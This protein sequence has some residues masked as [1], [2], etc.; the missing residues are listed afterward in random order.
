MAVFSV[1]YGNTM[2]NEGGY[3]NVS[4]DK[5]GETYKG[6][7][8][9][10]NPSWAGWA[11]I[12]QVK[13]TRKLKTGDYIKSSTL[14][15][16]VASF[17]L[18]NYWNKNKLGE[19]KNQ[20]LA[21]LCFDIVVQHGKGPGSVINTGL[22]SIERI[23]APNSVT[24]DSVRVMNKAPQASYNAIIAQ[25]LTY[26][27]SL[28]LGPDQQPVLARAKSFL[29]KYAGDFASAVPWYWVMGSGFFLLFLKKR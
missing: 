22:Q 6:V 10:Y 11:I 9:N 29:T 17:Y 15:N 1:A 27:N 3:R 16:L 26:I 2:S 23:S 7:A 14:D 5:G 24:A 20:S 8:R 18:G 4:Y 25:R 13:K 21:T 28:S 19:I 12:D